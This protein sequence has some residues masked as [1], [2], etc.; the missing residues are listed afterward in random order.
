MLPPDLLPFVNWTQANTSA[1]NGSIPMKDAAQLQS[2][3]MAETMQIF[4]AFGA[5]ESDAKFRAAKILE[6]EKIITSASAGLHSVH[7]RFKMY[8][9]MTMS[10]LE[11]NFTIMEWSEYFN[12]LGFRVD[13]DTE[14]VVLYPA[15]MARLTSFFLE[16]YNNKEKRRQV[17][18][19][20]DYLALSLVRSFRPYFDKSVFEIT[21]TE[22]DEMEESWKRCTFYTNKALGFATGAMYV[23]GTDSEGSVEKMEKLITFVKNAFKDFLL[24]KYWIDKRT[25]SNAEKKVDAIIDK[26]S[27]PSYILN[28]TFLDKYYDN[29]KV[30]PHDWFSNLLSWRRFLLGNMN[31]DLQ[32]L[33]DR[34]SRQG[35]FC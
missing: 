28:N 31:Y 17:F 21:E 12:V 30:I 14:V 13:G 2:V 23:K 10:Q 33:P 3:F 19:L 5:N 1:F 9:V 32:A 15:Y 24:N 6:V 35:S 26:I 16:Y 18:I 7:N 34:Q 4:Q 29:L 11:Q 8:N 20:R 27:Y 25:R 22:D